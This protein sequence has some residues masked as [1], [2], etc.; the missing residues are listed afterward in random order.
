MITNKDLQIEN[1][2]YTN[3]D[4][5]Q[6]YPELIELAKSLTNKW[7]PTSTNESDPGIVLIK[8]I[9][10]LGDKLNY[11]IDKNALEQFITSATQESS[12]RELTE[13]LGYNMHYYRSATSSVTFR[14]LGDMGKTSDDDSSDTLSQATQI[15]LKAF[16]TSFKTDDDVVYTL[17]NDITIYSTKKYTDLASSV[18]QGQLTELSLTGSD[19]NLIQL[20]N[21]DDN[22]RIYFPD[23]EVAENGIFINKDNG[24]YDGVIVTNQWHRVDNLND[25]ELGQ[26][27][28]KFGFDS[29]KGFPYIEFPSD[30]SNLIEDGLSISYI[31]SNGVLGKVTSGK[32]STINSSKIYYKTSSSSSDLIYNGTLDDDTYLINNSTSS[33]AKDPETI[34]EAYVNFKKTIGTFN[35]LV[36]C[37]DY[38]NYLRS[39]L[40]DLNQRLVSNVQVTDIR[41][42]PEYSKEIISRDSYGNSF[43]PH[44]VLDNSLNK[45][46]NLVLHGLTPINTT[47]NSTNIYNSTYYPLSDSELTTINSTSDLDNVKSLIHSFNLPDDR[48]LNHIEARYKLQCNVVLKSNLS[49]SDQLEVL[50]NIRQTLYTNYNSTT[51]DFGE[52]L[53]YDSLVTTIQNADSRIK[54]VNLADPEITY[55]AKIFGEEDYIDLSKYTNDNKKYLTQLIGDNIL[56]G[57]LPLWLEDT[58]FKYDY[59]ID[60]SEADSIK[61]VNYLACIK[62]NLNIKEVTEDSTSY[63]LRNNEGVELIQDS[64]VTQITYPAYIYYTFV[65]TGSQSES[66]D[67]IIPSNTVYKLGENETLYIQYTDSSDIV[68]FITYKNGDIIKPNF[69][70]YNLQN[71]AK[72]SD[73]TASVENTVASKFV[74]WTTK[75][76][77]KDLTYT[78]YEKN[79]T[80][81]SNITP[82]FAIGT[83]EQIDIL[84][85]NS[86]TLPKFTKCFW[87]I[88]PKVK[89]QD[90]KLIP[91]N[92]ENNIIFSKISNTDQNYTYILEEGEYFIYPTDDMLSLNIL[93][94]GTKLICDQEL[95]SRL[96]PKEI[97]DLSTLESSI[98]DSDVGTFEKSFTWQ[99]IP[100]SLQVVETSISNFIEGDVI[101]K[102]PDLNSSWQYLN[103]DSFIVKDTQLTISEQTN[104]VIRT[105]LSLVCSSDEPQEIL[106]NQEVY[107]SEGPEESESKGVDGYKENII[108]SKDTPIIQISPSIDIYNNLG[109]L[110][111]LQYNQS[112]SKLLYKSNNGHFLHTFPY[113]LINYKEQSNQTITE[114][115]PT[116]QQFIY[117]V[118]SKATINSRNEYVIAKDVV[119]AYFS[120]GTYK[121]TCNIDKSYN[122][123][124]S[125]FN[126]YTNKTDVIDCTKEGVIDLTD[127]CTN[128]TNSDYLYISIPKNISIYPYLYTLG[129]D[130]I[131]SIK[132]YINKDEYKI[133]DPFNNPNSYKQISSYT[134]LYSYLDVNNVYNKLTIAKI[135]FSTSTFNIIGGTRT[136]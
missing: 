94:S 128:V 9:A 135:D 5:G 85:L 104:P 63:I 110:Q 32:L 44:V 50:Q 4:F 121:L 134:P 98:R 54:M 34:N 18:I 90:N 48:T 2:S 73:S 49:S 51:I 88:R 77:N 111:N 72:I 131:E 67:K 95:I 38:S 69:D 120:S 33:E 103:S 100:C 97:I 78:L 68:R 37:R 59:N 23:V 96:N 70:I 87:Y 84:K 107:Y 43:Y 35:T 109:V 129:D 20:Y 101:E 66:R 8:L 46:L 25:Q 19:S 79:P 116:I 53:P 61:K 56:A 42:D 17:L 126:S 119:K 16:D 58:S 64:Y 132:S 81:Y 41:T 57:R 75:T 114:T 27:I 118:K 83:N 112:G 117:N 99:E 39:Y 124:I 122:L 29:D 76:I 31:I 22:N 3:K 62:T 24:V 28:F 6:I 40:D 10:F 102:C 89:L 86:V 127:F 108:S 30:I 60:L 136:W 105:M 45:T 71:K 36:S 123:K 113:K 80:L 55:F 74:D 14:Y 92:E 26:K 65:K 7:D 47:I 106:A 125:I 15:T 21:L 130:L 133:Y 93:G 12:M 115:T 91:E 13:L 11:N 82:L 1:I 52:E